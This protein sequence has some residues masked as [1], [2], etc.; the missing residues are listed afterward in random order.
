MKKVS[1]FMEGLCIVLFLGV[2]TIFYP[3][4]LQSQQHT[5]ENVGFEVLDNNIAV[6]E[7]DLS[8]KDRRYTVNLQLRRRGNPT[9]SFE[10]QAVMGDVGKG[11]FAGE[12]RKIIWSME[13]DMEEGLVFDPFVNDY[14]FTVQ[15]RR[16]RRTGWIWITAILGGASWYFLVENPEVLDIK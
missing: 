5:V 15:A 10:P 14:Y 1:G 13:H 12:N 4:P 6:I 2:L 16:N 3:T 7:Y 9:Y 8:G 11:K